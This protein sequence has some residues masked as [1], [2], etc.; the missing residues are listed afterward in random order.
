MKGLRSFAGMLVILIAL[1]AYLYFVESKRPAGG[2]ADKKDKAFSVEASA[3]D[4]ITIKSESGERTTL[5]KN[6]TDWQITQ[7]ATGKPDASAV[8]GLT[9][10]LSSL[11]VQR[12]IDENPS[13]LTEYTLAQPRVEVTFKAGG[14]DHKLQIGRKT[15]PGSDLYARIDDQKRVVLISSFLDT[16]F[17]RTAFDL[18]DKAV[19][20]VNRDEIGMLAVTTPAGAMKLEKKDGEW[21]MAEPV[22]ARADFSAVDGLVNRLTTLQMKSIVP[23]DAGDAKKYGLDKPAATVALG[24]GSSQATLAIGTS[25]GE[26]AVYA[27]DLSKPTV[28]TIDASLLDDLKKAPTEYRQKD[29]FDARA[30]NATRLEFV[31]NGVT[32]AFEKVKGKNKDGQE[33]ETWKQVSPAAKDADQTKVDSL[34]SA[35]TQARATTFVDAPAKTAMDKPEL[36]IAITSNDGKRKE[37][38]TIG[39]FA[40]DIF[41]VRAGEPGA[42]KIEATTLDNIVKALEELK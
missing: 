6:G 20:T 29:L 7:P 42:A 1:G 27:H 14:K 34:I 28:V 18:R 8:S 17:N 19:L 37:S 3:I 41:A 35:V 30:F 31:R 4:D 21:R 33:Q 40:V 32:T 16:T 2:A 25:S 11:E 13:D 15:P 24:S 36:T 9:T 22:A 39:K 38:V 23:P 12:V 26:G 10:N 5:H